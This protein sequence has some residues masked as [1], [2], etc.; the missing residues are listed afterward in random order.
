MIVNANALDLPLDVLSQCDVQIVDPPYSEYVHTHAMS[1]G[2]AGS[3]TTK[4]DF[5]FGSLKPEL[6]RRIAVAAASVKRWT[7]V[8]CDLESTHLWRD[9]MARMGAEYVRET[10]WPD[11]M[12]DFLPQRWLRWSQPQLSGDRPPTG[13]EATLTFHR[14]DGVRAIKPVR[15]RWNGRGDLTHWAAKSLRGADKGRAEKPLDL[16]LAIVSAYSD[17]GETVLDL[18]AGRGTT[19][20]ACALLGRECLAVELDADTAA[21]AET[22]L[23]SPLS[24]RDRERAIRWGKDTYDDAV[25]VPE[26]PPG[27]VGRAAWERAQRRL[28]DAAI[29]LAAFTAIP[30]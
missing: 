26:V 16:M 15:K 13:A 10:Y 8:F 24:E 19:A 29:V 21:Y 20:L 22:R 28:A 9:E 18:C 3:G 7:V 17:P 12:Y 11:G 25:R 14:A 5:G 23:A 30:T 1:C 6:M 27:E 4:R 2:S